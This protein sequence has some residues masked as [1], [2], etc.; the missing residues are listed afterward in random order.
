VRALALVVLVL[1]IVVPAADLA[2][3]ASAGLHAGSKQ[4]PPSTR[5]WRNGVAVLMPAIGRPLL[6]V[7]LVVADVRATLPLLAA[8]P[9]VPPRA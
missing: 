8:E 5:G 3:T 2:R 6:I 9:F 1:L 4:E 7:A